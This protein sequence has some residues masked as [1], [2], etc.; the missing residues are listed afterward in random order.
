MLNT[1]SRSGF[2]RDQP[3][4]QGCSRASPLL[5]ALVPQNQS[6]RE[7][8][9]LRVAESIQHVFLELLRTLFT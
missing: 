5:Q 6:N 3:V 1:S 8:E 9:E 7:P 4:I 2:A